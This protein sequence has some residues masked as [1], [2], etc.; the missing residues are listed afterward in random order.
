MK[1]L[2]LFVFVFYSLFSYG[3]ESHA[4]INEIE[5]YT[6]SIDATSKNFSESIAEGPIVYKSI[7]RKNGGW[8]AY[9]LYNRTEPNKPLRIR[10]S[11]NEYDSSESL[12][13]YYRDEKIVYAKYSL[14]QKRLMPKQE[15]EFH[16]VDGELVRHSFT[17]TL[18]MSVEN[19]LVME[20]E[21]KNHF[22]FIKEY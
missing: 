21:I 17:E 6:K 18:N 4:F 10:Y 9:Y 22:H 15:N 5:K 11:K 2:K 20:K 8:E 19:L 3:Q 13:I 1:Y 14:E 16:F 7:F 12:E